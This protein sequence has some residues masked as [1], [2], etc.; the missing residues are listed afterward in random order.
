MKAGF[1]TFSI[2]YRRGQSNG[3]FRGQQE[4]CQCFLEVEADGLLVMTEITDGYVLADVHRAGGEGI[5]VILHELTG[6]LPENRRAKPTETEPAAGSPTNSRY[7]AVRGKPP[8]TDAVD[9]CL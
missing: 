1:V 8:L 2:G 9:R 3:S 6:D 4:E 5:I 7:H